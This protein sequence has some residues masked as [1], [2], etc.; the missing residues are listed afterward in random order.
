MASPCSQEQ[1]VEVPHVSPRSLS[2]AVLVAYFPR[3]LPL[4][5]GGRYL[6]P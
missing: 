4:G 6:S 5:S 1:Q 2:G 3:E